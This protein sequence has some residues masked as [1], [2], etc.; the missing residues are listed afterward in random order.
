[1]IW[2]NPAGDSPVFSYLVI[3][4]DNSGW[5]Y[6]VLGNVDGDVDLE[7]VSKAGNKDGVNYHVDYWRDDIRKENLMY[8]RC[9]R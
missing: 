4:V 2:L 5:H 3:H 8:A 7:L 6:R 1:M 9:L